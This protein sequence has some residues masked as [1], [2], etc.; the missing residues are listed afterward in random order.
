MKQS[1]SLTLSIL[2]SLY[3]RANV[4]VVGEGF[5]A[6]YSDEEALKLVEDYDD[7]GTH[8]VYA[9]S[10]YVSRVDYYVITLSNFGSFL[11]VGI[12]SWMEIIC[13]SSWPILP[14]II[15]LNYLFQTTSLLEPET[16][17]V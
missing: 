6:T 16:D 5:T 3:P 4:D 17:I 12:H 2:K 8:R 10:R 7:G 13:T 9:W 15:P 1:A 11:H 14:W